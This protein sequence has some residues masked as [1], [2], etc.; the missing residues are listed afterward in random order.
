MLYNDLQN[1]KFV[2]IRDYHDS[3]THIK[4]EILEPTTAFDHLVLYKM[5]KAAAD[6]IYMQCAGEYWVDVENP[7]ATQ[8]HKLTYD[9][10]KNL[11]TENL[12]CE[13]YLSRFGALA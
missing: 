6:G 8:L 10:R 5:C 12:T 11:H 4:T 7:C 9:E 13:Q 3:W 1:G 2:T